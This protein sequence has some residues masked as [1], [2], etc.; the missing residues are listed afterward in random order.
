MTSLLLQKRLTKELKTVGL[1][2]C[3]V[4]FLA[5]IMTWYKAS[6]R[7]LLLV[8]GY[9]L[10]IHEK[11]IPC[12]TVAHMDFDFEPG[13][14]LLR[15]FIVTCYKAFPVK[16]L[17]VT[18]HQLSTHDNKWQHCINTFRYHIQNLFNHNSFIAWQGR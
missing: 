11:L 10:K 5:V 17:F 9:H 6:P 16:G 13:K 7:K 4:F 15:T 1:D 8:V 2:P 3:L 18:G 14:L 12:K